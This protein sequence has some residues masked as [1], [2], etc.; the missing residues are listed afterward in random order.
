MLKLKNLALCALAL[1]PI[2][3]IAQTQTP[4]T[5]YASAHDLAQFA[6]FNMTHR[7]RA[8]ILGACWIEELHKPV[9]VGPSGVATTFGW[10]TGNLK[11]GDQVIFKGGGQPGVA[12]ALYSIPEG[13]VVLTQ[14]E[15]EG[16]NWE[17]SNYYQLG[18]SQFAFNVCMNRDIVF[19]LP[20]APQNQARRR[21]SHKE[22]YFRV[23]LKHANKLG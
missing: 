8:Q 10:F 1:L 6:M 13:P 4:P 18:R 22:S 21:N 11:S 9:F 3:P 15:S 12:T 2:A 23:R 17:D 20:Y 14:D 19:H 5:A 16:I 7:D